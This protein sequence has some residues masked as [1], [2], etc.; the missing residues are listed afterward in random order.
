[1]FKLRTNVNYIRYHE[2]LDGVLIQVIIKAK[3]WPLQLNHS[4]INVTRRLKIKHLCTD[5][6][7][8]PHS[9]INGLQSDIFD[10]NTW[11]E[12]SSFRAKLAYVNP[13]IY[14]VKRTASCHIAYYKLVTPH[15]NTTPTLHRHA[16]EERSQRDRAHLHKKPMTECLTE[17]ALKEQTADPLFI[18]AMI[19]EMLW[20]RRRPFTA[21]VTHITCS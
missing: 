4:N 20:L 2:T 8:P 21:H 18:F 19:Y 12:E 13:K 17:I 7:L 9:E 5:I 14:A 6:I 11:K 15:F 10:V 3:F 16:E 1:M